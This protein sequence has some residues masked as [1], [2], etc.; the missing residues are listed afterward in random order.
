MTTTQ[1]LAVAS[2]MLV[3]VHEFASLDAH[4]FHHKLH[5][6][7]VL[8]SPE[9]NFV[10]PAIGPAA[11]TIVVLETT[12]ISMTS[13]KTAPAGLFTVGDAVAVVKSVS[14]MSL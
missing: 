1:H 11:V 10:H 3:I 8:T 9:C 4:V 2:K 5:V 14:M 13:L 7:S 6:I 12:H